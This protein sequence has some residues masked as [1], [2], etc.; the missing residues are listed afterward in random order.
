[1]TKLRTSLSANVVE[2]LRTEGLSCQAVLKSFNKAKSATAPR[3]FGYET[4]HFEY[5]VD[6]ARVV[7]ADEL[8]LF[9][10]EILS[11]ADFVKEIN[12][13]LRGGSEFKR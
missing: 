9:D 11:E 5:D 1:M 13:H 3:S 6:P 8:A 7:I 10:D 2:R 4:I 12:T